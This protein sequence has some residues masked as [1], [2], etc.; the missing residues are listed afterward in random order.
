MRYQFIDIAKGIG[1]LLVVWFHTSG[2]TSLTTIDGIMWGSIVT[3]F[4]MPLFFMLSGI[5]FKPSGIL[6]RIKRL[7]IPYFS[8]MI[9]ASL[10]FVVKGLIVHKSVGWNEIFAPFLGATKGYPN[11]PCWFLL[12]LAQ[13]SLIYAM[14]NGIIKQRWQRVLCAFLLSLGAYVWG[15]YVPDVKY[16]V[17]VSFLCLVFMALGYE[18]REYLLKRITTVIGVCFLSLSVI[19][20][21][22]RPF[23]TNVSQNEI[24]MGY[25]E[26]MILAIMLSLGIVG[27]SK[28]IEKSIV[29]RWLA[30]WG[31][32]S[33]IVLC[34]HMMIMPVF[35]LFSHHISNE[36]IGNLTGTI[37]V[38]AV[39]VPV[40]Y[41]IKRYM[42][43]LIGKK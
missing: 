24:P 28:C 29:G 17:D 22:L 23:D 1:I 11:T 38:L 31:E 30:Y 27:I 16:Y 39:E 5:F 43:Y 42:P 13:I 4:Y 32:N 26:F 40:I 18:Y 9:L 12:S 25:V 10:L 19:I 3:V 36:W 2:I 34:T 8:F 14:V 20:F 37:A 7:M 35:S 15:I 21:Y 41:I 6:N 33:L